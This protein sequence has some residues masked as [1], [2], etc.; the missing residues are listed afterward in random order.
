MSGDVDISWGAWCLP[1]RS[2]GAGSLTGQSVVWE[3]S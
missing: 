2:Q 1:A 3:I